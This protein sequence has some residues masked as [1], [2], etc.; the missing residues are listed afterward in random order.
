MTRTGHVP[1]SDTSADDR[2]V[3]AGRTCVPRG[4]A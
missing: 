2:R 4:V 3:T 1:V